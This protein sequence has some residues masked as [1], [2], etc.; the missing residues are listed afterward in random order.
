[1]MLVLMLGFCIIWF[2]HD[3]FA[4]AEVGM[5]Y[6]LT[7]QKPT[8]ALTKTVLGVLILPLTVLPCC[9]AVGP[10]LM[11]AKSVIFFTWAQSKL[12]T[13]FRRAAAERYE[14]PR[15]PKWLRRKPRRLRMPGET[16]RS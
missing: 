11:V 6:G 4:V 3:L 1:M 14:T 7:A 8:Q 9:S 12:E 10:G 2:V 13:E 15:A 16:E 5:W